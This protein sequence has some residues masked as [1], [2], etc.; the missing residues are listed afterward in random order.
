MV[1]VDPDHTFEGLF[2][3][4]RV[5]RYNTVRSCGYLSGKVVEYVSVGK[6]KGSMNIV[7]KDMNVCDICRTFGCYV[8]FQV[9]EQ[10]QQPADSTSTPAMNAFI[11]LMAQHNKV[12]CVPDTNA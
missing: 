3:A 12:G 6:D 10:Q 8:K 1:N 11:F 9:E 4:V 5:G 2:Q 7:S